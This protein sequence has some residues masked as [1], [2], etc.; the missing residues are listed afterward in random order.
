MADIVRAALTTGWACVGTRSDRT[1]IHDLL[2][3]ARDWLG[4][5]KGWVVEICDLLDHPTTE[6]QED[7]LSDACRRSFSINC[8]RVALY[9]PEAEPAVLHALTPEPLRHCQPSR[10]VFI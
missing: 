3:L 1:Q 10:F 2:A 4:Q 7:Q 8:P 6:L 9:A 5:L